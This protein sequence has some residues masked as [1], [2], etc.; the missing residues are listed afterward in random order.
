MAKYVQF[1]NLAPDTPDIKAAP[2]SL[3]LSPYFF[4]SFPPPM[5]WTLSPSAIRKSIHYNQ[6]K[7]NENVEG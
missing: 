2:F 4:P 1:T 7:K 5:E 6:L 3:F